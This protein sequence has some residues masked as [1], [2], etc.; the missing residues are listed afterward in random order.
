MDPEMKINDKVK[1]IKHSYETKK[2]Y[3]SLSVGDEGIVVRT[4]CRTKVDPKDGMWKDFLKYCIDW[5]KPINGYDCD[6]RCQDGYGSIVE[7][8]EVEVL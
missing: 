8:E 2:D 1:L 5:G 7:R 3:P 6:G 4:L